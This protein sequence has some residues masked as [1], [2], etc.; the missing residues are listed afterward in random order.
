MTPAA[1]CSL[2]GYTIPDGEYRTGS[3]HRPICSQCAYRLTI[4]SGRI[5]LD[6]LQA[7]GETLGIAGAIL[8]ALPFTATRT[9]GFAV[10]IVGNLAWV[11]YGHLTGN[12]HL[13]RMFAVYCASALVGLSM[14]MLYE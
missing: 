8:V 6:H 2:C 4:G 7:L 10:W 13:F 3:P 5:H 1:T 14:V 9:A 12:R 11:R